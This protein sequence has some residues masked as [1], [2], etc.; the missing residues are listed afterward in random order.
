MA[1]HDDN[2][3]LTKS[4]IIT[5][6]GVKFITALFNDNTREALYIIAIHEPPKMQVSHFNSI[7]ESI[8]PKMPSH[9]PI[10]IIEISI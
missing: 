10:V 2:V 3:S 1:L 4:T 9:C 8:A 6:Y 5:N 7:L